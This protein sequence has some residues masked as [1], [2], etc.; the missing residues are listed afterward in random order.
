VSEVAELRRSASF[1]SL[2][3]DHGVKAK[4]CVP[5]CAVGFL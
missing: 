5:E 3:R 4:P 2:S 1:H